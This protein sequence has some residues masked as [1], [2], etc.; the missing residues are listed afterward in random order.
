[1]SILGADIA[2]L[3]DIKFAGTDLLT[4]IALNNLRQALYHRLITDIGELDY[5]PE[6]GSEIY[7]YVSKPMTPG[8]ISDIQN[9]V[10]QCVLQDP[11]VE[12]VLSVEVEVITK[13][14]LVHLTFK[15]IGAQ[16]PINAVFPFSEVIEGV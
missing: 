4:V 3:E 12:A 13:A 1:M 7:K 9:E 11:R 15:A 5:H 16:V 2:A 8:N 10:T 6:Y 14:I